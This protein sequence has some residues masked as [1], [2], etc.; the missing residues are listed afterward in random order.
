M[1][2]VTS[3]RV[4]YMKNGRPAGAIDA[5]IMEINKIVKAVAGEFGLNVSGHECVPAI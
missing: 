5:C 4:F 2:I 3:G 1:V